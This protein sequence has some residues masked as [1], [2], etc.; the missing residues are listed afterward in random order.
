M[1]LF[2]FLKPKIDKS[3]LTREEENLAVEFI[4]L[5]K[6]YNRLD[7]NLFEDKIKTLASKMYR[8]AGL[9][10]QK[11]F[12]ELHEIANPLAIMQ[13]TK[14]LRYFSIYEII[15]DSLK[16]FYDNEIVQLMGMNPQ[17]AKESMLLLLNNSSETFKKI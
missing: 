4:N 13:N 15:L 7:D 3:K 14:L 8:A 12:P 17:E 2:D 10:S 1:G 6:L 9:R 5:Q 16:G 11:R